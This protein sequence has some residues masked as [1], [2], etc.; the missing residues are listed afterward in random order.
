MASSILRNIFST[1]IGGLIVTVIGGLIVVYLTRPPID[2]KQNLKEQKKQEPQ[3]MVEPPK[4]AKEPSKR[5]EVRKL[6]SR[7][8][9]TS[10]TKAIP[11]VVTKLIA[12]DD[13]ES[14]TL[15]GGEGWI[16]PWE[17]EGYASVK[18]S[19][20]AKQGS[21]VAIIWGKKEGS[22]I[23]R[24]TDLSSAIKPRLRFWG[25]ASQFWLNPLHSEKEDYATVQVSQDKDNWYT[26]A[27]WTRKD[28]KKPY[29]FVEVDLSSYVGTS[30]FWLKI[31]VF[32]KSIQMVGDRP[33]FY[34]DDIKIV[35]MG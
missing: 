14:G 10:Q 34:I 7:T 21:H 15:E 20:K 33:I 23:M 31:S 12:Q 26:V 28:N 11:K 17:G 4:K 35:D 6:Q 25:R 18:P 29:R 16:A 19:S 22:Y 32:Y 30:Q 8:E 3:E 1:V 5:E 13:F 27:A 9:I 2:H 24:S